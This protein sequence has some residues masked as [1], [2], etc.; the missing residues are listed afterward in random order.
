MKKQDEEQVVS[1]LQF[2]GLWEKVNSL[3][4]GIHTIIT[5]EFDE[6]G[7][8]FSGGECQ[9]LVI[10]R[11][12][13]RDAQILVFGEPTSALD[14]MAEYDFFEKIRKMGKDR[15][16]VYVSHRLS[17]TVSEDCIYLIKDGKLAE[18]GTQRQLMEQAGYYWLGT[19][20]TVICVSHRFSSTINADKI[21]VINDNHI[22]EVGNHEELMAAGGF[23]YTMFARQVEGYRE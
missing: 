8:Y 17:A 7:V 9:K 11:A 19:G 15:T 10:A 3:E 13:V 18:K 1:A 14:A 5:K 6:Q 12:Y 21:I 23:Y 20:K 4:N 22:A 2:A 16:V